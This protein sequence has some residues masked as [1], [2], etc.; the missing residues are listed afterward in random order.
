MRMLVNGG[1]GCIGSHLV[2]RFLAS[3]PAFAI[4]D[5]FFF[6]NDPPPTELYPL[7]LPAALPISPYRAPARRRTRSADQAAPARGNRARS[8]DHAAPARGNRARSADHAAFPPRARLPLAHG[9]TD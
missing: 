7:P 5:Y 4:L 2:Q 6:F 3:G 9:R 1:A 8:A